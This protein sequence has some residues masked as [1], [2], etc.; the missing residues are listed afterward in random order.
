DLVTGVQTCALPIFRHKP[1]SAACGVALENFRILSN[2]PHP[3][4]SM[5][6][7]A[8]LYKQLALAA[9]RSPKGCRRQFER[10]D[11]QPCPTTTEIKRSE[12]RRVGKESRQR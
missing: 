5:F 6:Q 2:L 8:P 10:C 1:D 11:V 4:A 9:P 12:E 7:G 3:T